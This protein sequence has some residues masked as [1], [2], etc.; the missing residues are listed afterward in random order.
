VGA[1]GG[2]TQQVIQLGATA[3]RQISHGLLTAAAELSESELVEHLRHAVDAQ[4]LIVPPGTDV[5]AFRHALVQEAVYRDMLQGERARSDRALTGALAN[6]PELAADLGVAAIAELAHHWYAAGDLERALPAAIDAGLAAE[7]AT[8]MTEAHRQFE[9]TV[10]IWPRVRGGETR[11]DWIDVHR[12][13][14][15]RL[16]S[17]VTTAER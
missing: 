11:L 4:I 10:E 2:S 6:R 1:L 15:K 8:A 17:S 3:G 9:R 16:I 5:Y 14:R 12:H 13:R 7:Q